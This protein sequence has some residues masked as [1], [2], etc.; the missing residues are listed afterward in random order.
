MYCTSGSYWIIIITL[1][2]RN[3]KIQ[4][5]K[6]QQ[7]KTFLLCETSYSGLDW[8]FQ[9]YQ[10]WYITATEPVC[11]CIYSRC[12]VWCM[13]HLHKQIHRCWGSVRWDIHTHN[14]PLCSGRF[15]HD[16]TGGFSH[17][18]QYLSA[19][20]RRGKKEEDRRKEE[21]MNKKKKRKNMDVIERLSYLPNWAMISHCGMNS[22]REYHLK[23]CNCVCEFVSNLPMQ[24]FIIMKPLS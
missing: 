2:Y 19:E 16:T 24:F 22:N 1:V 12:A 14:C 18:H 21:K 3:E 4:N 23:L 13:I 11:E 8:G 5:R 10:L 20:R 9:V 17:T 15:L 7:Q 6:A